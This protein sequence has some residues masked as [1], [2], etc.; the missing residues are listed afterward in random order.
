VRFDRHPAEWLSIGC[1]SW[2]IAV[3]RGVQDIPH[4][5]VVESWVP[6]V[7]EYGYANSRGRS[8]EKEMREALDEEQ[9]KEYIEELATR[10]LLN[11]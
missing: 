11:Q 4:R 9:Y 1:A 2:R 7:A 5:Q 6:A 3:H 10:G 8:P